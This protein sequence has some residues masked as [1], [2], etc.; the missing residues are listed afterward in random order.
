MV[1]AAVVGSHHVVHHARRAQRDTAGSLSD[2]WTWD[3][4]TWT[5]RSPATVPPARNSEAMAADPATKQLVLFGGN[6]T[7]GF[8]ER[9]LD[10]ERL[11]LDSAASGDRP[12]PT[13]AGRDGV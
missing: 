6:G 9:H 2:T 12:V 4:A 3:G 10:L 1:G 7:G 8:H 13:Y 11:E 5:E